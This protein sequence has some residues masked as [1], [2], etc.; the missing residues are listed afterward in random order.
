[1]NQR[2]A[3]RSGVFFGLLLIVFGSLLLLERLDL[4]ETNLLRHFWPLAFLAIGINLLIS[5]RGTLAVAFG[6]F[7][8]LVGMLMEA[9]KFGIVR[10]RMRDLWPVYLIFLGAL[11][12]WRALRPPAACKSAEQIE[13]RLNEF[14]VFGGGDIKVSTTRFEGGNLFAMFG[15]YEIDFTNSRIAQSPAVINADAIFGGVS[16]R[17]PPEWKVT[18][19]GSALLGGFESRAL[20]PTGDG[21]EQHLIVEGFSLFGGVE[22]KN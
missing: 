8:V 14:A 2:G 9:E 10:F 7:L 12:L 18:A 19:R 13:S 3:A 1:M 4:L 15:G 22:I 17:V 6:A 21:A 5:Q 16:M 11:L 20:P